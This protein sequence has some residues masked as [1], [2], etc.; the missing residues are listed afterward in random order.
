MTNIKL[1]IDVCQQICSRFVAK[2]HVVSV[3]IIGETKNY[4]ANKSL[5]ARNIRAIQR[6]VLSDTLILTSP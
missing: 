1:N 4:F 2:N 3:K 6:G 5:A